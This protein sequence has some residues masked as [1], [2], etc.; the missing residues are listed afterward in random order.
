MVFSAPDLILDAPADEN[1]LIYRGGV[2]KGIPI[3]TAAVL[4]RGMKCLVLL[5]PFSC[6][7]K[8]R[9]QN[10][11]CISG[12]GEIIWHA[13][14]PETHDRYVQFRLCDERIVA[15]SLS[16]F[17]VTLEANTGRVVDQVFTK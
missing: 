6:L 10:L 3:E 1:G 14:L 4:K 7:D 5:D 16:G 2:Y 8:G 11:F 13:P 17:L 9:F 12:D 15:N